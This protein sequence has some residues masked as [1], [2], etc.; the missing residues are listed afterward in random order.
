MPWSLNSNQMGQPAIAP[1]GLP[2]TVARATSGNV[3]TGA[4]PYWGGGEFIY[5]RANGSI[6]QF[7]IC[8]MSPVVVAGA[9]RYEATEVP[10][11]AN[12]GRSI[13][14][15][16]TVMTV[17]QFGWFMMKG[18]TPVNCQAAVAADT[19]FGIAA[20]GQGGAVT[21]GK[22]VLGGRI[23][24]ASTQTV[25]KVGCAANSGSLQLAIPSSDGW[26]T[27]IYLS[28]TGIA[29]NTTVVDIT[30]DGK[31]ATLSL[32]TTAAVNSTI[33]GTYNNATVFYNVAHINRP[34]AQGAIT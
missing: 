31:I 11:T 22:Q 14:I 23:V 28:G 10:N 33:T 19:S 12:L 24:V 27:G 1:F 5:A 20:A 29:A 9:Y 26:F 25:A 21:A 8:V 16:M 18:V 15:A 4:D 3:V 2:D 6:R 7:G 34:I 30:P 32:A 13:C 17:G